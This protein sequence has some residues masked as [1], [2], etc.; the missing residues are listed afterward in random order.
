M[1]TVPLLLFS[2]Y[3]NYTQPIPVRFWYLL[4]AAIIYVTGVMGVTI[5]GNVPLN[6]T[7]AHFDLTSASAKDIANQRVI[8]EK[9]WILLHNIRTIASVIC[10]ILVVISLTYPPVHA[11]AVE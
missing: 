4:I 8:F 10:L 2:V 5:L 9:S 11:L 3:L 1:G 7:L 6:E